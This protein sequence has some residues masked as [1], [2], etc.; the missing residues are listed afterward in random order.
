M[1]LTLSYPFFQLNIP[2]SK[3]VPSYDYGTIFLLR[4]KFSSLYRDVLLQKEQLI[5]IPFGEI[6][7][8]L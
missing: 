6:V 5:P 7:H 2:T 3:K 8:A 1:P 4:C